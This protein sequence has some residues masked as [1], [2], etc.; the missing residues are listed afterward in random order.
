M[1]AAR[2]VMETLQSLGF[3]IN[4]RKSRLIP[5]QSFDWL[6]LH[7][8][9]SALQIPL[10]PSKSEGDCQGSS[11]SEASKNDDTE[12]LG[13]SAGISPIRVYCRPDSE[14]QT[15][16]YE[17]SLGDESEPENSETRGMLFLVFLTYGFVHGRI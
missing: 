7:W 3:L 1:I 11:E 14:S 5:Q 10:P 8:D 4:F 9:L 15:Q 6:G 17:Q 13:E 12:T 2:Q 16:G